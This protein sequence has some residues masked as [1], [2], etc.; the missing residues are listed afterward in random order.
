MLPVGA[1][2]PECH[3]YIGSAVYLN[4]SKLEQELEYRKKIFAGYTM[5]KVY[6]AR[7]C[8]IVK[9]EYL[10]E[11]ADKESAQSLGSTKNGVSIAAS[12]KYRYEGQQAHQLPSF[13]INKLNREYGVELV[14]PLEFFEG[15]AREWDVII[16]GSQGI[17]LD[18]NHGFEYPYVS[19]GS[20]STYGLLD[21]MGYALAPDEVMMV[22][23]TYGSYFGPIRYRGNFE[24]AE[25]RKFAGE[26]G[27][28]TKR[29]RNLCWL[30]A[31][32]LRRA[33]SFIRPTTIMLN[34]LD[35]I[36]W[37]AEHGKKWGMVIDD[38]QFLTF[39]D[40]PLTRT[41]S[42]SYNLTKSGSLFVE[43]IEEYCGAKVGYIGVGPSFTDVIER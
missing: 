32:L 43:T 31:D 23:K 27:T 16:E 17:G 19:A 33:A 35:T 42:G 11:D 24:D 13:T 18:V 14:D 38:E 22:L 2:T 34:H 3:S 28:T 1:F 8:H 30:D 39:D 41:L 26:Y 20:F 4:P 15:I 9:P 36:M 5:G 6:I 7:N 29:P 25:F 12:Y 37:F 40:V 21:G 10:I